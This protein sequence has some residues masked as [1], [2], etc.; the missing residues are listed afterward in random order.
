ML[1]A[2]RLILIVAFAFFVV[3][4]FA[5]LIVPNA[6]MEQAHLAP[7]SGA[8]TAEIRGLIGGTFLAWGLMIFG[9]WLFKPMAKGLLAALG[10]TMA[11]IAAA[12]IVSLA[13]D[14][15][16]AFSIPPLVTEVLIA[17]ACWVLYRNEA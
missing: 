11:L 4:G 15:E 8:G 2:A 10:L 1:I 12:R 5:C 9:A 7:Q 14:Q 6:V 3:V 13:V 16:V 17:L